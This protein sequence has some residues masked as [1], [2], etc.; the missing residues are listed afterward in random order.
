MFYRKFC[1]TF[2]YG[3]NIEPG[4][5]IKILAN[6]IMVGRQ[7]QEFYFLLRN[8]V[9]NWLHIVRAARFYLNNR[10]NIPFFCNNI[11]L[12]LQIP[13]ISMNYPIPITN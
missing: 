13:V 6:N 5:N 12:R 10:Q 9:G 2:M 11:D 4:L 3:N 7:D 8:R 1:P